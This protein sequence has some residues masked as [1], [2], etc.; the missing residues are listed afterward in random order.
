MNIKKLKIEELPLLADLNEYSDLE[1]MI[2]D[3]TARIKKGSIDIWALFDGDTIIGELRSMYESDDERT[4][5]CVRAYL[6]AFR[7]RENHRGNGY[8]KLLL[9]KVIEELRGQGYTEFTVGVEDD[10]D[11]ARHIYEKFGFT[12]FLSRK[13]EEYQGDWYEYDLLMRICDLNDD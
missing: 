13:S 8:G 11:R 2:A 9:E 1:G 10:N 3:N 5:K 7:I 6:Y 4:I 12:K